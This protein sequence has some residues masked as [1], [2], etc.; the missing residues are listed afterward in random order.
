MRQ[1][2]K[3]ARMGSQDASEPRWCPE[4]NRAECTRLAHGGRTCHGSAVRGSPA[5]R[6][7]LGATV[8]QTRRAQL[9]AWAAQPGD[10]G[11]SPRDA[12]SAQLALAWRRAQFLG[13]EL[14]RQVQAA[15][16]S[17]P[18]LAGLEGTE[19]DR[20][21]KYAQIAHQMGVADHWAAT[22]RQV[23]GKIS[24][25]LDVALSA[26]GWELRDEVLAKF[27]AELAAWDREDEPGS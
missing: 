7:H 14:G 12:V 23:G 24:A 26:L 19:R 11:I 13:E 15:G 18:A 22:A 17:D 16:D 8:E 1:P 20:V 4:H 25:A 21:V 9:T 6:M 2:G 10:H 27:S 5:C 3:Q